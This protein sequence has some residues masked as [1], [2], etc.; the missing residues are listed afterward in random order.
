M[1]AVLTTQRSDYLAGLETA[2]WSQGSLSFQPTMDVPPS[3]ERAPRMNGPRVV[4]A[5]FP[6]EFSL[7]FLLALTALD[8]DVVALL[9][10][11]AAHPA[12]RGDNALRRIAEH[13]GVPLLAAWD[14]NGSGTCDELAR[15]MPDAVVMASF[16]QIVRP[17]TLAIPRCGWLNVH[18]SALPAYR[19]PEPVYWA[20]AEGASLAGVTLHRVVPRL[21]AGPILAQQ[22]F[23]LDA[24]ETAGTLTYRAARAGTRLLADA[25]RALLAGEPGRLPDLAAGSYRS[26]IGTVHLSAA[27]S[28]VEAERLVRAGHPDNPPW[29]R[30]GGHPCRVLRARIVDRPATHPVVHF[31]DGVLEVLETPDLSPQVG[32]PTP[33]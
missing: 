24:G 19:G 1:S 15:L 16:D 20:L 18:P 32:A 2:L 8:V 14:V 23:P 22:T 9:T 12:V 33:A 17:S 29:A 13:L 28:A 11:P 4:F 7:A 25:L 27:A 3:V 6:S 31:A 5:G 26:S 10:S 21:D 30:I